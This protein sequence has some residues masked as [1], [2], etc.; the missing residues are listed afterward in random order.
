MLDLDAIIEVVRD[1]M[2]AKNAVREKALEIS[3][4]LIRQ[5][6]NAI[7]AIHRK[8][9]ANAQDQLMLARK[10][11]LQLINGTQNDPDIYFSGYTQDAL[12]EYAEA[13]ILYAMVRDT[14]FP[15]PD[16]LQ[17][18]MATYING[19][20][21][22]A[23][24]LR[25]H[26]L[27]LI[28][29]GHTDEAERLLDLMEVVYVHLISIDFTEAIT[30]GL[31]RRTDSLRAVLERTRGDVTTSLRQQRLQ[32]AL[33]SLGEKLGLGETPTEVYSLDASSIEEED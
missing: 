32:E 4:P 26:I 14:P 11:A 18:T 23:S 2:E 25:R 29:P 33:L 31:R 1:S 22:A 3:R 9:W 30:G 24:E 5:A 7:R 27:D 28:R 8:E 19:M 13:Y 12:K 21:E 6:A 17:I 10:T 16:S 20:A 15:S